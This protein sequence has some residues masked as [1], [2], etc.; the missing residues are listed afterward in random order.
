MPTPVEKTGPREEAG[1][2]RGLDKLA[3]EGARRMLVEALEAE[4][5]SYL[6]RQNRDCSRASENAARSIGL[7]A[8]LIHARL[9]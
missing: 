9:A 4:V 6:E 7:V 2:Y 1:E 5:A 3:R 8:H